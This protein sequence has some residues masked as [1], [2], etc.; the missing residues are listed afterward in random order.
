MI[1]KTRLFGRERF[2]H[3]YKEYFV[4]LSNDVGSHNPT[5]FGT[6]R[7]RWHSFPSP[8]DVGPPIHSF[9]GPTSSMALVPFFNRCGI[10]N[11]PPFETQHLYWLAHYPVPDSDTICNSLSQ[12]L[13]DIVFFRFFLSGFLSR[14]L[15]CVY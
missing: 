13:P 4:L 8:I 14:F 6:E 12:L 7:P 2:L 3:S 9:W 11:P 15:K 5:P 10:L 1:F